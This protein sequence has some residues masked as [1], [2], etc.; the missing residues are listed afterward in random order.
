MNLQGDDPEKLYELGEIEA[1][2]WKFQKN[3]DIEVPEVIYS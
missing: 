3:C 1:Q 2:L